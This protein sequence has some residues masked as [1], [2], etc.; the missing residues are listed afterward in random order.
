VFLNT[1][2]GA[3]AV[4]SLVLLLWQWFVAVRF[5]LHRRVADPAF[6]PGVTLLKPLRGSDPTT[7]DSLR[8]WFLQDYSGPIQILFGVASSD[9]PVCDRVRKLIAEFPS[10]EAQQNSSNSNALPNTT[11][12]SS[13]MPTSASPAISWQTSSHPF[14]NRVWSPVP[15]A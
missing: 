10:N 6:F 1:V 7:E 3:L 4:L 8:S 2:L 14:A 11:S 15:R 5:P 9:D 12:S 13:A